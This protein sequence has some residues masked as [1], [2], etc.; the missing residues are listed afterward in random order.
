MLVV[1]PNSANAANCLLYFQPEALRGLVPSISE[2]CLQPY[3]V[4]QVTPHSSLISFACQ[5]IRLSL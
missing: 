1:T 2:A 5:I 3:Q 4:I